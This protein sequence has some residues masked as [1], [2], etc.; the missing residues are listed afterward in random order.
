MVKKVN[1]VTSAPSSE[2]VVTKVTI[3]DETKAKTETPPAP[4]MV[5]KNEKPPPIKKEE[6]VEKAS[7]S[8]K[9]GKDAPAKELEAT[10]VQKS[11][12]KSDT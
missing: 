10:S 9:V 4:A 6:V 3:E 8:E 7:N 5:A 1:S 12:L 2:E 11:P